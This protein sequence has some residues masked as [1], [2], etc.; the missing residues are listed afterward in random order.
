[1]RRAI[2]PATWT[3]VTSFPEAV[4]RCTALRSLSVEALSRSAFTKSPGKYQTFSTVPSTGERFECTLKTFMNT[5][6]FTAS[7]PR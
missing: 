2:S 1:M 3:T 6:T 5:L 7:R 4:R